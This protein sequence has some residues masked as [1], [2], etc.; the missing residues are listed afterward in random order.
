MLY[1]VCILFGMGL[2]LIVAYWTVIYYNPKKK[3]YESGYTVGVI[4]GRTDVPDFAI[5]GLTRKEAT[6]IVDQA[7]EDI[8]MGHS[9]HI[10]L[11]TKPIDYTID[12][13]IVKSV[14][15]KH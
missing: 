10:H 2:G 3:F 8:N 11:D 7:N 14:Y 13:F 15:I 4:T 1:V 6:T 5:S 9:V 12:S